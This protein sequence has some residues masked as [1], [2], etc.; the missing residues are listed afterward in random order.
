MVQVS[1]H[2]T[3]M[4]RIDPRDVKGGSTVSDLNGYYDSQN[5]IYAF[6]RTLGKPI[7]SCVLHH[8]DNHEGG[9]GLTLSHCRSENGGKTW[10]ELTPVEG[11]PPQSHDGYQ[12]LVG[13]R[14]YVIYGWNK[15]SQIPM[16]SVSLSRTDMQLDDGFWLRWSDDFGRSFGL[17]S[18]SSGGA[19]CSASVTDRR[20]LLIPVRRTKIDR[21]NP[22]AGK[23]T[24]GAFG[25][26]KP[27]LIDGMLFLAFQKTR[28]GNGESYGSEVFFMRC[29][30]FLAWHYANLLKG[31]RD[32]SG[33]DLKSVESEMLWETLP[34]DSDFGLQT[35]RGL[36]LGEEPHIFQLSG[37]NLM[38][39]WRTE[40]GFLDSAY[41][42]DYGDT[43][44]HAGNRDFC[45]VSRRS[46]VS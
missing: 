5:I 24:I 31:S 34:K 3:C 9:V 37:P 39:I 28:D 22:W 21:S 2:P 33:E 29:R 16:S 19:S 30:N 6:D 1:P 4:G 27:S 36:L 20:R 11:Y 42:G 26:D 13:D 12:I 38:C 8:S 17:G 35:H 7:L 15:G 43:W 45:R 46:F 25:C 32:A 44:N 23:P 41:S 10:S 40:L 18:T 14:I